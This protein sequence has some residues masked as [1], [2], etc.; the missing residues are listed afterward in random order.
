MH[1]GAVPRVG[2]GIAP[3]WGDVTLGADPLSV[4]VPH[5]R[6]RPLWFFLGRYDPSTPP[7]VAPSPKVTPD[8]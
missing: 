3:V 6:C 1:A 2:T 4:L 7:L 8:P 5:G